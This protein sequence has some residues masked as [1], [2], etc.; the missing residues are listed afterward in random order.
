MKTKL[1]FNGLI[2]I[3]PKQPEALYLL[4]LEI[5]GVGKR[6]TYRSLNHI[7]YADGHTCGIGLGRKF[8]DANEFEAYVRE[9]LEEQGYTACNCTTRPLTEYTTDLTAADQCGPVFAN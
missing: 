6:R 2:K 8:T 7:R 9:K 5:K 1:Q 3:H 4:I